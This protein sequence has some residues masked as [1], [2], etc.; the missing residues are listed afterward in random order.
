MTPP[1]PRTPLPWPATISLVIIRG[2]SGE[3]AEFFTTPLPEGTSFLIWCRGWR[4]T[5]DGSQERR[6]APP[7]LRQARVS[8]G[9]SVAAAAGADVSP[10]RHMSMGH[11]SADDTRC[12]MARACFEISKNNVNE[13]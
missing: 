7:P 4:L 2:E 11:P 8:R 13:K 10:S 5:K 12:K 1:I 6:A 3:R 9:G